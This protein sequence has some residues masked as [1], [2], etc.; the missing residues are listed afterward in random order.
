MSDDV[1]LLDRVM[2]KAE[3]LVANVP[4]D[5]RA[6]PTP[7]AEM[8]VTALVNHMV[9]WARA[10]AASA[11]GAPRDGDP[12]AYR[13]GPEP[14]QELADAARRAVAALRGGGLERDIE[15]SPGSTMPGGAFVGL[16]LTEY[17]GHGWDLAQATG[18]RVPFDDDEAT[19]A[20]R[21][22]TGMLTD[23]WR[24]AGKPFGPKVDVADSAPAV[25]R[26]VGFLGRTP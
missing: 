10:L 25:D 11:A 2:T 23:E 21:F 9:G 19:A 12:N 6:A 7:C 3:R 17:V 14:A 22:A 26:L 15:M 5:R 1:D 8:D 20:L 18:Q 4:T 13:S 16:M 24:G